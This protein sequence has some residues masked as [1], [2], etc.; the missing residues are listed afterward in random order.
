M[1]LQAR[2]GSA[3]RTVLPTHTLQGTERVTSPAGAHLASRIT[4]ARRTDG[5]EV[6]KR[7][8][9]Q[10]SGGNK[11]LSAR[12]IILKSGHRADVDDHPQSVSTVKLPADDFVKQQALRRDPAADCKTL[13]DLSAQIAE[14]EVAVGEETMHGIRVVRILRDTSHSPMTEWLA[15]TLNCAQLRRVAEF[16]TPGTNISGSS[17]LIV[18]T[19]LIGDPDPSLFEERRRKA[20]AFFRATRK[21]GDDQYYAKVFARQDAYYLRN[22][23]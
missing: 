8:V 18:D 10:R 1:N 13:I 7:E 23:P 11:T 12:E 6:F 9:F 5:S 4:A 3:A 19:V 21:P 14:A 22:R 17:E 2:A 15:P 16:K 20:E